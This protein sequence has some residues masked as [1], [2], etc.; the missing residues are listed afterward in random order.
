[1]GHVGHGCV[2]GLASVAGI[3]DTRG[4][5]SVGGPHR[6]LA[7]TRIAVLLGLAALA[8]CGDPAP[9]TARPVSRVLLVGMD[10]LEWSVVRPLL[11]QGRMPNLLALMQ[12]GSYGYLAS[13]KPTLIP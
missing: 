6:M 3:P 9:P 4:A 1:M 13:M 8:G 7:R 2:H 10:G 11:A 12:R 5:G